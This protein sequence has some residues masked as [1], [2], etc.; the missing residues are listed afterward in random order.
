MAVNI[1]LKDFA[2]KSAPVPNDIIYLGNSA[3]SFNEVQ[4]TIQEVFSAAANLNFSANNFIPKFTTTATA[5]GTTTLTVDSTYYQYFTGATT[6]TLVMPVASTLTQ[7]QSWYIVNNSTGNITVNSSGG[8]AIQVMLPNTAMLIT[9][10]LTSGTS[11]ASWEATYYVGLDYYQQGVWTPEIT[12]ATPGDLSVSY[13]AQVGGFV[14]IGTL[15]FVIVSL[16]FTPTYT[17]ASGTF[18]ITGLPFNPSTSLCGGCVTNG[19]NITL[20]ASTNYYILRP[21]GGSS[22]MFLRGIGSGVVTDCTTAQVTSGGSRNVF[23]SV[24]YNI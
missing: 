23:G 4:S 20:P 8:N 5:A 19:S 2:A 10:Q 9:C 24:M 15:V 22:T 6:Q 16:T 17:T 14:R 3:D 18:T 7:G 11:A 21:N 1:Q 13:G 12:F